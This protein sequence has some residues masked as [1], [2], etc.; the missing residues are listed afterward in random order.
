M[1]Q[2]SFDLQDYLS[3]ARSRTTDQFKIEDDGSGAV[4][5]D[6]FLQLLLN[7]KVELQNT[8]KDLMQLR[9]IDTATGAQLDIIGDI[10][11]QPR[12][13]ID[14]A[15]LTYFAY[16]GYSDAESYGD[17]DN[18]S[19]GGFYRG[20]N[21]P[22]AGNT[23]LN[24]DQYRLFIRAKIIKNST[25]VTPPQ[26]IAFMQFVFGI[27]A[28]VV[29]AEG[30]AEFTVMLG[31]ELSSF[32]K[33]LLNYVSYSSGYP[34]RFVP[35]PIGVR[36]NFGEFDINNYF[37]FQGAPGAKG[38]GDLSSIATI[39]GYGS[40]YGVSYGGPDSIVIGGGKYGSLL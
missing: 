33:V 10:V 9:S 5:F 40:S 35:K 39:G 15:L 22:L 3:V 11:G 34:S 16:Q 12:E 29:I 21:D 13:L 17:L 36:V 32:E 37:G 23:V 28:T 19:T 30:N 24:D 31:R 6:K 8:F 18:S 38:Y 1:T 25:N 7:G 27:E 2:N 14:T 20:L 26:F 4:V